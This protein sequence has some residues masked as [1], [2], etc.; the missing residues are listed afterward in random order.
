[1]GVVVSGVFANCRIHFFSLCGN[2]H[3][4][5]VC[6]GLH[7]RLDPEQAHYMHPRR[8]YD[9]HLQL[10]TDH[11]QNEG[12]GTYTLALTAIPQCQCFFVVSWHILA[13]FNYEC[14]LRVTGHAESRKN[15]RTQIIILM[16]IIYCVCVA[17]KILCCC[18]VAPCCCVGVFGPIL[19]RRGTRRYLR[20]AVQ[21]GK[22]SR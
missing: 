9:C 11:V 6:A 4:A 19:V 8:C 20:R 12:G 15:A 3:H 17:A 7:L 16:G 21:H 18:Y 10:A 2:I 22:G 1:M 14:A 13:V 5:I